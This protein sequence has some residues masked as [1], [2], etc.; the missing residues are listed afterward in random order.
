[1]SASTLAQDVPLVASPY[2]L[3]TGYGEGVSQPDI[4]AALESGEGGFV[5]SVTTGSTVDGPGVR[6]VGWLA[7]CQFKCV[8]CHNP[9][10]WKMSNGTPV[11]LDRAIEVIQKYRRGLGVMKG[12]LTISGGEPLLQQRFVVRVFTAA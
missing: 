10:T 5:H 12:G 9:D 11:R 2:E 1:M 4:R 3:R 6:I 8:Y 7:G